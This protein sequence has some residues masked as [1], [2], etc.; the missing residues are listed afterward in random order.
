MEEGIDEG[1][2]SMAQDGLGEMI[3]FGVSS[4]KMLLCVIT[5]SADPA[6]KPV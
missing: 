5:L 1:G 2:N 4:T 6:K 3:Y